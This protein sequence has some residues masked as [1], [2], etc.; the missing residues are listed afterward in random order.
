VTSSLPLSAGTN[1]LTGM[2]LVLL[3]V[4]AIS[5]PANAQQAGNRANRG[6]YDARG[7]VTASYP[8][9]LSRL[10]CL[11]RHRSGN[12]TERKEKTDSDALRLQH[13]PS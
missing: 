1:P 8:P 4:G 10:A 5:N 6:R 3:L 11:W 13:S 7:G 2:V 12:A 9:R